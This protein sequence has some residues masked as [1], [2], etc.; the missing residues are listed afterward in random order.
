MASILIIDDDAQ[1]R[2]MLRQ[3]L[4]RAGYEVLEASNGKEG[5]RIYRDKPADLVITDLIMPEKEGIETIS[6][7]RREFPDVKIVAIS[8]GGKMGPEDYLRGAKLLGAQRIL[9][10][11]VEK[12]EIL[13]AVRELINS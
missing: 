10:K 3:M 5:M 6:D 7:L 4:S 11:P 8:G 9:T 1:F 2:A 12:E 13:E